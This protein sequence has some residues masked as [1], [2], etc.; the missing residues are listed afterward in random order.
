[1][2][3]MR[4]TS[5]RSDV[6]TSNVVVVRGVVRGAPRLREVPD[7][8][9]IA[10]FDVATTVVLDTRATQAYVPISWD[11]PTERELASLTEGV[12]IVVIG[13]VRR[14]FFRVGGATQ[15]RT[16]VVADTVVPARRRKQVA[17]AL[18]DTVSRLISM[19]E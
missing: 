19:A 12:E 4:T 16:E 10:Q 8:G 18:D 3:Q 7:R 13:I 14:R 11:S 9:S 6:G 17:S 1:M 15:S 2:E 5:Q